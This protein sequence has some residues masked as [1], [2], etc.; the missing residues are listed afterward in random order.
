MGRA[1]GWW[2]INAVLGIFL[3]NFVKFK[4]K[5]MNA[6]I[7][8]S[9]PSFNADRNEAIVT[10]H[11]VCENGSK[12]CFDHKIP[13]DSVSSKQEILQKGI[14]ALTP[15]ITMWVGTF[16]AALPMPPAWIK[17]KS[18]PTNIGTTDG[19]KIQVSADYL[20]YQGPKP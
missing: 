11:V 8:T 4:S 6:I 1:G 5:N 3:N 10:L 12:K 16:A 7:T 9:E 19:T 18:P 2:A 20:E 14:E 13:A 17:D 15:I